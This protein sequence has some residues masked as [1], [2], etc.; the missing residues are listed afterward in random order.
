MSYYHV[1]DQGELQIASYESEMETAEKAV[2]AFVSRQGEQV[3]ENNVTLLSAAGDMDAGKTIFNTQCAACHGLLGEGGIGP[4][5]TDKYWIHG[6]SIKD[7]FSTIKYGVIEK[8]MIPWKDQLRAKEMQQVSSYILSL[9]GTNPPNPKAPQGE[10]YEG[11]VEGGAARD[12]I[13]GMK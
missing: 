4:N 2:A 8:G 10:L 9:Q 1:F 3:D 13:I 11:P 7:V 6:G 5:M 12:T